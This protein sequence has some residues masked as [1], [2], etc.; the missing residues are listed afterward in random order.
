MKRFINITII[1]DMAYLNT[2]F[3]VCRW[4]PI[5]Q[6]VHI[7]WVAIIKKTG[8]ENTWLVKFKLYI[9]YINTKL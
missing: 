9:L 8:L 6:P 5:Q 4:S 3:F 2:F 7:M 1:L